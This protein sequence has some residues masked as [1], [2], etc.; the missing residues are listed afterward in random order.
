MPAVAFLYLLSFM[1]TPEYNMPD[2]EF[3]SVHG[4]F[5]IF[6]LNNIQNPGEYIADCALLC[7]YIFV[8]S[9]LDCSFPHKVI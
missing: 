4:F 9:H 3:L 2:C 7:V 1:K 6:S 8:G 5:D